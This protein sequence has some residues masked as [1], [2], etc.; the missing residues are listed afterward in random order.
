V[1]LTNDGLSLWYGTPDAPAPFDVEVVPRRGASLIV[2][3]HPAN[4]TN[5]V[6]VRYR[7]DGGTMQEVPGREIRTDYDRN[8][9]YFAVKFPPLTTGNV[10]EYSPTLSSAGRQCPP[11]QLADRFRSTFRLEGPQASPAQ[12]SRS[13]RPLPTT[14][15]SPSPQSSAKQQFG[16]D[17]PFVGTVKLQFEAPQYIGEIPWGMRVNLVVREGTIAGGALCGKLLQASADDMLVRR[18]G[19]GV[20]DMRAVIGAEDGA[21]VDVTSGGYVDFGPD[22]YR[23][24]VAR[25]LPDQAPIVV[26][27]LL[28]TKHPKY[29]WLGR[30]QCIGVGQTHL[31]AGQ[32]CYDV[33]A[34]KVRDPG[35][36]S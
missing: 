1:K 36:G 8:V 17:L 28:F 4:P 32:A 19:M 6:Q 5:S 18:D 29:S 14:R 2:A 23:R 15:T 21:I 12:P 34:V 11:A 25:D 31:D 22:G 9:Q 26:S 24:A 27:P 10:V 13:W 20:V 3:A 16:T 33:Y 7:V 35:A 30:L